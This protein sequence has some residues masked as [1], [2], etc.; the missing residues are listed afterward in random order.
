MSPI[1]KVV[2]TFTTTTTTTTAINKKPPVDILKR[3]LLTQILE[4][5]SSTQNREKYLV[6]MKEKW[7]KMSDAEKE[8]EKKRHK[9]KKSM[10]KR[11][12]RVKNIKT[13][14]ALL[15]MDTEI[16]KSLKFDNTDEDR[17]C[18]I[19]GDLLKLPIS[20][21]HLFNVPDIMETVKKCRKFKSSEQVRNAA[22]ECYSKFVDLFTSES[23]ASGA[24]AFWS[25]FEKERSKYLT[26]NE[27]ELKKDRDLASKMFSFERKQLKRNN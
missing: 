20:Q 12:D 13:Q 22:S 21:K 24:E 19:L 5:A 6:E 27:E 23:G 15:R 17:C 4:E 3:N 25:L 18:K 7:A 9:E 8:Q 16:K 26:E 11:I 10:A 14:V 2:E 1:K